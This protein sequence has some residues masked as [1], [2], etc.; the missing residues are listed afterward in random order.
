[1]LENLM[2]FVRFTMLKTFHKNWLQQAENAAIGEKVIT[3]G[4]PELIRVCGEEG[5]VLLRN[6]GVLPLK[7]EETLA[8]FGRCQTDWFYVGY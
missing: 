7:K 3:E 8:V 2:E 6:E 4:M 1:M 5:I